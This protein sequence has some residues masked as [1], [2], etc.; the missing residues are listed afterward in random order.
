MRDSWHCSA[1]TVVARIF[2]FAKG[3]YHTMAEKTRGH[4]RTRIWAAIVYPDSAPENWR[5]IIDDYHL[6]WIESPLHDRDT[7]PT[8][9]EQKKPHWHI[10]LCFDGP[11]S[12]EQVQEITSKVNSA[13]PVKCHSLKG[14]VRYFAHLDNPEKA[15]YNPQDIVPHGGIDLSDVFK[16]TASER[17]TII[18]QMRAWCYKNNI[19]EFCDLLDYASENHPD[20]WF[21]ILCDNSAYVMN[22][23]LKS[24]HYQRCGESTPK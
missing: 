20:D 8:T 21:P 14:S 5:E 9:G 19:T 11:K 2:A 13:L 15:Q 1:A 24:R 17:Y 22:T 18:G 7:N 10:V 6:E 3:E 4:D 23:Y 16:P 12:F